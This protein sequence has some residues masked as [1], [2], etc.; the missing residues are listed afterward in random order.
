MLGWKIFVHSV[1]MVFGN[2]T[3]TLKIFILP[4]LGSLCL[5]IFFGEFSGTPAREGY[6]QVGADTG[7]FI[8]RGVLWAVGTVVFMAWGV[9]S[10]HRFILLEEYPKGIVPKFSM[11][12]IGAYI[13]RSIVLGFL[14]AV[15]VVPLAVI[16]GLFTSELFFSAF[17][18]SAAI[19]L[20]ANFL[21]LRLGLMLPAAALESPMAL[22]D[23]WSVT[24]KLTNAILILVLCQLA[25]ETATETISILLPA[26]QLLYLIWE[27]V[28]FLLVALLNV[29]I[30]T[31]MYGVFIE[32]RG[33]D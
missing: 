23:A 14:I 31:T 20:L 33:L 25:V 7:A 5:A 15:I 11:S 32:K 19:S 16:A 29:S 26:G 9:V 2:A 17:L 3:T 22:R 27:I 28:S 24:G 21:T 18:V 30:L 8:A 12:S 6:D 13:W 1:R 4:V 10:W